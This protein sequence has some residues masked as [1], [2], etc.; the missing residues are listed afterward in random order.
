MIVAI[1]DYGAGNIESVASA[2]RQVG[3]DP[4]VARD[5]G[6]VLAAD[7]L[8]LPGVGAAGAAVSRL[9]ASGMYGAL[10]EAV[11]SR[12]RP[13][14]GICLG[15]E[16]LAECLFEFG[17]H[18]GL[19]WIPGNVVHLREAG[20]RNLRVPHMGW[21]VVEP[22]GPAAAFFEEP[23]RLRTFYFCHSYTLQTPKED[24]VAA[25]TAYEVPLVAAILEGTV[26]ATQFHPEKSQANGQRLLRRFLEWMP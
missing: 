5:P 20:V 1:I 26:L 16:L 18:T 8:I 2:I 9:H 7:R 4:V 14:L 12:A 23:S 6:A 17:Q 15:M 11:R 25:R 13:M 24:A 10:E 22:Q 19:A 3:A 21:N